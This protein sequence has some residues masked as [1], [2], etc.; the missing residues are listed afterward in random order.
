MVTIWLFTMGS[1]YFPMNYSVSLLCSTDSCWLS[2]GK[3]EYKTLKERKKFK[4]QTYRNIDCF[5]GGGGGDFF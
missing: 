5:G 3:A 1:V 2:V 4:K